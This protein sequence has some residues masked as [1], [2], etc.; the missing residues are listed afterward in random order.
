MM[1]NKKF[2]EDLLIWQNVIHPETITLRKMSGLRA[3]V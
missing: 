2:M 1:K 3:V